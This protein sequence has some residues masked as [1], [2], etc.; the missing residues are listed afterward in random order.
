MKTSF[1]T[2]LELQLQVACFSS[3]IVTLL[4]ELLNFGS[5]GSVLVGIGHE[6]RLKLCLHRRP[7]LLCLGMSIKLRLDTIQVRANGHDECA[8]RRL[9]GVVGDLVCLQK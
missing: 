6:I 8:G 7:I 3:S 9:C 2:H 5:G 1:G 4:T